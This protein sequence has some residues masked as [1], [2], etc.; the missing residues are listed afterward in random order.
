M[1]AEYNGDAALKKAWAEQSKYIARLRV[2]INEFLAARTEVVDKDETVVTAPNRE[3]CRLFTLLRTGLQTERAARTPSF[4]CERATA[5]LEPMCARE[6]SSG[7][8]TGVL[9]E[10]V[11]MTCE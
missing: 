11:T 1:P 7:Q 10:T 2:P 4:N 8:A 9:M 5:R 3:I 6:A